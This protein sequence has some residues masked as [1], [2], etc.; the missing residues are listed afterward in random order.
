MPKERSVQRASASLSAVPGSFVSLV[1]P[2]ESNTGEPDA[3]LPEPDVMLRDPALEFSEQANSASPSSFLDLEI[4]QPMTDATMSEISD[5]RL[6]QRYI[7]AIKYARLE[8]DGLDEEETWHRS[9]N[10]LLIHWLV[11]TTLIDLQYSSNVF[12]GLSPLAECPPAP[13]KVT[14]RAKV[15]PVPQMPRRRHASWTICE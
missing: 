1:R 2:S 6:C 5:I 14:T 13:S 7:E 10:A 15:L 8:S 3:A 4:Q 12:A 9:A 11:C